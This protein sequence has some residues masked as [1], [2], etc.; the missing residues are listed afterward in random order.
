[1]A[2]LFES[3]RDLDCG[4]G[5]IGR[6]SYGVIEVIDGEFQRI[7]FRP[8]PKIVSLAEVIWLGQ[9]THQRLRA[10]AC[11]LYFN[12]PFGHRNFLAFKYIV[13]S[14]GTSYKTL[15]TAIRVL[16]EVARIKHSDAILCEVTNDR[17]TDPM[18]KRLGWERHLE[19]SARR[20]YIKRFYGKYPTAFWTNALAN[21]LSA[22]AEK[23]NCI[24]G[25]IS[26]NSESSSAPSSSYMRSTR[27]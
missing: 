8:W 1:M 7:A 10:D 23:R 6:R 2:K 5:T 19:S 25:S 12:Q 11:R 26:S 15:M 13:S 4:A 16:D 21:R 20:H 17:I 9:R 24:D 14:F 22:A 3:V 18:L 27:A